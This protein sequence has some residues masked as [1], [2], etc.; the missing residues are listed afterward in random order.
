[1]LPRHAISAADCDRIKDLLHGR[2]GQPGWLAE[3]GL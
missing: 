2:P 3:L 1:M